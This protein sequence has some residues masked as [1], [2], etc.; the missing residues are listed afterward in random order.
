HGEEFQEHGFWGHTS[1]F[2]LEQVAVPFYVLGPG[3]EPGVETR[4]TS[5]LDLPATLLES[6]GADP[7]LRGGWTLGEN[8]LAPIE[9]RERSVAGWE[10]L[11]LYTQSGIFRVRLGGTHGFD[12]EVFDRD[13]TLA[14]DQAGAW[15]LEG[16]ALGRLSRESRRFL[17][18]R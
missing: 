16:E 17:A 1:N 18:P 14:A 10:H 15:A 2:T 13:W 12:V 6:L 9:R 11:G 8:L 7:A 5:H 4:P 3:F